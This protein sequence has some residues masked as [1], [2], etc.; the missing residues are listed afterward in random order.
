VVVPLFLVIGAVAA[1]AGGSE[2]LSELGGMALRAPVLAG[3]FLLTTFA[4]L[5][6]P[7][8]G[9]FVGEILVLFGTFEDKLVYGLVASAGAVLSAVYMI[10][11]FQRTMHNREGGPVRSQD[12]TGPGLAAIAAL[13]G[14]IVALGVYPNFVLHRSEGATVAKI[15]G[16]QAVAGTPN[17]SVAA[18]RGGP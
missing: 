17:A 2:S 10:R 9:N 18:R 1:R 13:V 7:G 16:A 8:S 4:T 14:V 5:A 15:R 6:M 3:L 11:V 12:V